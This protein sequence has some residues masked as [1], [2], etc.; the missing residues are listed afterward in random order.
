MFISEEID[1]L[2]EKLLN[3]NQGDFLIALLNS[4]G[5]GNKGLLIK[6]LR[7]Y[8]SSNLVDNSTYN[9]TL[10]EW[11]CFNNNLIRTYISYIR[12][13]TSLKRKKHKK[14]KEKYF[15]EINELDF[16]REFDNYIFEINNK[17]K[18][19]KHTITKLEEEIFNDYSIKI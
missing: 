4:K 19:Y 9:N 6:L 14:L 7:K 15:M 8:V 13:Y 1:S 5:I 11:N 10:N 16:S 12:T 2:V 18:L 3:E 17:I